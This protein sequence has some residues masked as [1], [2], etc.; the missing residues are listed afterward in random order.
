MFGDENGDIL[1]DLFKVKD[2]LR[3]IEGF[4]RYR[5]NLPGM[6]K[7]DIGTILIFIRTHWPAG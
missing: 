5:R 6:G 3:K 7:R 1:D 2:N 4:I